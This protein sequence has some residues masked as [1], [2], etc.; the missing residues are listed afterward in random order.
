MSS[1]TDTAPTFVQRLRA[2]AADYA[3]LGKLRL[4]LLVVISAGFGYVIGRPPLDVSL[5]GLAAVLAGGLLITLAANAL[6][7]VIERR[8]DALMQRT[9]DRPLPAGRLSVGH[10]AAFAVV[11]G[12]V[13]IGLIGAC[14]N[15]VAAGWASAALLTYAFVYT[16]AKKL[17]VLAVPLGAFPGA[18]P[19]L[20]GY[21]GATGHFDATG[22]LLFALQYLWQF[23]HF[24]AV[25]WRLDADY[26]RA[27][28][29]LLPAGRSRASATV[30]LISLLG[31]GPVLAWGSA[32]GLISTPALAALVLVLAAFTWPAVALWRT[33]ADAD[34]LRLMF[35]SF[36]AL[37]A[38]QLILLLDHLL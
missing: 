8:E 16:P 33:R 38:L 7:E 4:A 1:L 10:A 37:P 19:P 35:A 32:V 2:R 26:H 15:A 29:R 14:T 18:L 22:G 9:A 34:A 28:Y 12:A 5:L 11:V 20:I 13:G 27:G 21:V 36:L 30:I 23:P 31:F 6:N 24:W 25:A 17:G 3:Q